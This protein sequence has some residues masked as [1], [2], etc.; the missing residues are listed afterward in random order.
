MVSCRQRSEGQPT[1]S[2]LHLTDVH[3][4]PLNKGKY[5]P[6]KGIAYEF[7][8]PLS[9]CDSPI[10]LVNETFA[11]LANYHA[12]AAVDFVV[13]TGDNARH[14]TDPALPRTEKE[15]YAQNEYIEKLVASIFDP[16]TIPIVPSLG[17][18]DVPIHNHLPYHPDGS[19]P[20]LNFYLKLWSKY[21][22]DDQKET[23][24]V[25][26]YLVRQV[27]PGLQVVALNTLYLWS[28][29]EAVTECRNL[30][31]AGGAHLQWLEK[32]LS[33]ARYMNY[34]VYLSGHVAP[35]ELNYY[36][37]CYQWF[38]YLSVHYQ[39]VIAANV[40]G[41]Q[42]LDHF[43]FPIASQ[44]YDLL[45]ADIRKFSARSRGQSS[46]PIADY[47]DALNGNKAVVEDSISNREL[48]ALADKLRAVPV[49]D[50]SFTG[51][52]SPLWLREYAVYLLQH[53]KRVS[54]L[55]GP[56]GKAQVVLVSPA[57]VPAYNSALRI[58]FYEAPSNTPLLIEETTATSSVS[59]TSPMH[60]TAY[61]VVDYKQYFINLTHGSRDSG[62]L[63]RKP[64]YELEYSPKVDYGMNVAAD[65][66]DWIH[67]SERMLGR[68][69][70]WDSGGDGF[71]SRRDEAARLK[72]LY[73]RYFVVSSGAKLGG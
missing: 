70:D 19:S 66:Q 7:G 36:P 65:T 49:Y 73:F 4:D 61:R 10:A 48:D 11:F 25:G 44:E 22:P 28:S 2:F 1:H 30:T 21:I 59:E 34:R 60:A 5:N 6:R 47:F 14:D 71:G 63:S 20:V 18:N 29:N 9:G 15:V 31:T 41:H 13:W 64:F 54:K 3:V 39:D 8:S 40:Y 24:R 16:T 27:A 53:Y 55:K 51:R 37:G 26:G 58:Y 38:S 35:S 52:N 56:A 62:S 67:F 57:V 42:N 69:T 72:D 12:E 46:T 43:F 17:N 32:V 23:F 45:R 50:M 33:K 68:R